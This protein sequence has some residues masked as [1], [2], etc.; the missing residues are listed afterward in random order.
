MKVPVYDYKS[1]KKVTLDSDYIEYDKRSGG[2]FF[3]KYKGKEIVVDTCGI[4]AIQT[5][6]G[7]GWCD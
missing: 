3:C 7:E 4:N 6:T 5:A 1:R 2:Y